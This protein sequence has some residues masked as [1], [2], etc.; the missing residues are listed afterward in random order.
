[1]C[2]CTWPHVC[3]DDRLRVLQKDT[4]SRGAWWP[5]QAIT[6]AST[7]LLATKR[8]PPRAPPE[9]VLFIYGSQTASFCLQTQS[10][11]SSRRSFRCSGGILVPFTALVVASLSMPAVDSMP[12]VFLASVAHH[13]F[14]HHSP[15]NAKH[16]QAPSRPLV[17]AHPCVS[18]VSNSDKLHFARDR[19]GVLWRIVSA[20]FHDIGLRFVSHSAATKA[21]RSELTSFRV[22]LAAGKPYMAAG[23]TKHAIKLVFV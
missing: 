12:P 21:V 5:R 22:K 3:P 4:T 23:P 11:R 7:L 16:A 14:R 2:S 8:F 1:M 15:R 17:S 20:Q 10:H 9:N 19:Q 18:S 13:T 6:V